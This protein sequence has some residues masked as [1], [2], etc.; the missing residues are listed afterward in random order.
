MGV[1]MAGRQEEGGRRKR[2]VDVPK[3]GREGSSFRVELLL[4]ELPRSSIQ[5]NPRAALILHLLG[6]EG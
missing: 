1:D 2:E 6:G 4:V 3:G 5:L